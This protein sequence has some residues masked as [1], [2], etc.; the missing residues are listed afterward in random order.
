MW[1]PNAITCILRRGGQREIQ[2]HTEEERMRGWSAVLKMLVLKTDVNKSRN[3]GSCC[4]AVRGKIL[5]RASRGRVVLL[6][7]LILAQ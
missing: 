2:L 3:A 1:V 6:M 5:P 4:E 7:F